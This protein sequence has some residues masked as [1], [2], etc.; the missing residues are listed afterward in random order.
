MTSNAV[1]AP[2]LLSVALASAVP[3]SAPLVC[4]VSALSPAQRTRHT[5]LSD[6]IRQ[7]AAGRTE[8]PN[9][10]AIA[11]DFS[12]LPLDAEGE[13]FCVVELAQWV[14]LESRCCPF[15]EFGIDVRSEGGSVSLRLTGG[16]G[17]KEFL[18]KEFPAGSKTR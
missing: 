2:I 16:P 7:A 10:Y 5:A 4:N 18:A 3:H 11:L 15:L 14:D 9:G 13:P 1:I 8:L 17:V 6:K 12:R